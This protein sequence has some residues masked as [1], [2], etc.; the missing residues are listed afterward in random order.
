MDRFWSKV[1]KTDTCWLWIA[2]Q[3]CGYGKFYMNGKQYLATRISWEMLRGPIPDGY[4]IDHDNPDYGCGNPACVN[5][6]HLEPVTR[7][8][9][10]QRR[11][12]TR[13]DNKSGVEGVVWRP[14]RRK[15]LVQVQR[16]RVLHYGGYFVRFEDAVE[17]SISLRAQLDDQRA[18]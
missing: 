7:A 16:D 17:A 6:E 12:N 11:R 14:A 3:S 2:G 10:T 4:V 18:A 13:S 15:W 5:P 1:N 8:V 9:N